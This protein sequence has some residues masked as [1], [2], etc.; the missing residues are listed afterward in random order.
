MQ[1]PRLAPAHFAALFLALTSVAFFSSALSAA[2]PKL[3]V[4]FI[5]ADDLRP[6]LGAYGDTV[7]KTPNI[8]RLAARGLTFD[9]AYCQM[10][11]CSPSRISLLSG[12]RPATTKVYTID[13]AQTVRTHQPGITTLPQHFKNEGYFTRSL[14]K[15]YHVGIDDAASWT[16]PAWQA[17]APRGGPATRAAQAARRADAKQSGQP[18]PQKGKGNANTAGPAFEAV[19]CQDDDLLDGAAAREAVAVLRD[20]AKKPSEPFFLAVGFANPHV[21]W[22]APKK[23]FDLYDPAKLT[24]PANNFPP[25]NAPAFAAQTGTDFTWYAGVPEQKPLP[26][27]YG[28]QCL[29]AYLAAISYVDAQIGRLLATLEETGLDKNTVVVLWGDHGYYMGEHSWWGGKHNNYEGA[30]RVPLLVAKPGQANAGRHSRALVE[31]VDLYP[32]LAELC[33]LPAPADAATLEG[34]SF[35][36]LLADPN[37]AW[38]KAAFSQYPRG[39]NLGTAM[40][41]DRW[42]YV[43]WRKGAELIDREL[44]DHQSDPG[45]NENVAARPEHAAVLAQLSEQ[46]AAGWKAARP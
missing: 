25:K 12:R 33:G 45:E 23:Y 31:L 18:L 6:Q 2:E 13:P 44:Y 36:P 9:R 27:D 15:I 24:L 14:G 28:R 20:R 40:R 39:G 32:S 8:D 5:A 3:N 7:V 22:I 17:S 11:L 16:V 37:R 29:H 35:A 43:E 41:T 34:T 26:A 38:K 42:R 10:A 21:P 4:L 46:L 30:T 1:L 19:D